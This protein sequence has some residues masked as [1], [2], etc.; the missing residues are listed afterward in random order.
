MHDVLQRLTTPSSKSIG[1]QTRASV[2]S[3]QSQAGTG[4]SKCS[5]TFR[6]ALHAAA[7][8]LLS[9]NCLN[10]VGTVA[11]C[12]VLASIFVE[13]VR[14]E[15]AALEVDQAFEAHFDLDTELVLGCVDCV[16]PEH[17]LHLS[18]VFSLVLSFVL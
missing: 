6:L 5:Q 8:L 10:V 18:L 2:L 15:V 9:D 7:T 14:L 12:F 1:L 16:N 11:G 13:A 17:D 4:Y 3:Q